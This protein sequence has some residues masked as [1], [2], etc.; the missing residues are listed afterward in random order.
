MYN[1]ALALH[2]ALR[3]VILLLLLLAIVRA[4][5]GLVAGRPWTR[6]D[7]VVSAF[8]VR[9]LDLQML[10]GLIIYFAL[11]P[12]TWEGMRHIG[13]AMGNAGLR[14]FTVEH[15][16]GMVIAITLAHIG[17]RRI[18]EATDATRRHRTALIFFTLALI[19]ILATIPWPGRPVV[20][21]PLLRTFFGG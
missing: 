13:D 15:P 16:V 9:T 10:I 2:S 18:R 14:F 21:R 19:A 5:L 8:F 4:I 11:S 1:A 20:G 17:E 12:I 6:G 7:T 3:W